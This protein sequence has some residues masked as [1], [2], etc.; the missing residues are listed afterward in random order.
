MKEKCVFCEKTKN[1]IK[2]HIIPKGLHKQLYSSGENSKIRVGASKRRMKRSPSGIWDKHILCSEC[3]NSFSLWEKYGIEFLSSPVDKNKIICGPHGDKI[4]Y[5][6]YNLDCVKLQLFFLSLLW[7]A[8]IT[9]REEYATVSLG[10]Y[11]NIIKDIFLSENV[12]ELKS[13]SI[14]FRRAIKSPKIHLFP[15]FFRWEEINFYHLYLGD[16]EIRIKVDKQKLPKKFE[17]FSLKPQLPLVIF[18]SDFSGSNL[19]ATI[20][21]I[22]Q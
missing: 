14:L 19:E 1:L 3:D 17:V 18:L 20:K 2:A 21:K 9:K 5:S 10:P 13:F 12:N 15:A 22:L 11:E 6:V 7:K 8:S 16:F 4:A